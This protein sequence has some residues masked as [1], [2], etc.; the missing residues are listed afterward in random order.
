MALYLLKA[1]VTTG[2]GEDMTIQIEIM[3]K[4]LDCMTH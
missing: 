2:V 3:R 1:I 4:I